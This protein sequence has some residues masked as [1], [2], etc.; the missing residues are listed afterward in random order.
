MLQIAGLDA[1][2]ALVSSLCHAPELFGSLPH[3]FGPGAFEDHGARAL[4]ECVRSFWLE[5]TAISFG[6]IRLNLKE[7]LDLVRLEELWDFV[8]SAANFEQYL[9]VV[10][11]N[12]HRRGCIKETKSFLAS[13]I[14]SELLDSAGLDDL[15]ERHRHG[16]AARCVGPEKLETI[17][18]QVVQ[19]NEWISTASETRTGVRFGLEKL[20]DL[21]GSV[22]PGDL[23]VIGGGTGIGKSA[24]ALQAAHQSLAQMA[25]VY[26]S[27][28]MPS[29][30]LIG[31]LVSNI[32]GVPLSRILKGKVTS[33]E[34]TKISEASEAVARM[35]LWIVD[36][37]HP[38]PELIRSTVRRLKTLEV[39]VGLVIVDY[40]QLLRSPP[41]NGREERREAV[42]AEFAR[43]L[44][45]MAIS[46]NVVLFALSQ[47]NDDGRLR[48]SRAIG[49][50]A[51]VV[52]LINQTGSDTIL[53]IEKHR[54]GPV[55]AAVASFE[56]ERFE[57]RSK[58][59]PRGEVG[60]RKAS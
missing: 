28:E 15:I 30:Q 24:L 49:Q 23:V 43:G 11:T 59:R 56:G 18:D 44:K 2:R 48:E 50:H 9:A 4:Y 3:S 12:M 47:L 38:S 31:R 34:V 13:L 27:L 32:S 55:G 41:A 40:L 1:E 19:F 33:S 54:N 21:L 20:D 17:Q 14:E 37:E 46:E 16:L 6:L 36:S 8:P 35:P 5:N 42:V 22:Q 60:D 7:H 25:V 51:D 26:F 39:P 29:R 57:F 52:V 53:R 45:E 10:L 58:N